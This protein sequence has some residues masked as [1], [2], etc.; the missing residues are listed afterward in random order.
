MG[1]VE[2]ELHNAK[3]YATKEAAT[4]GS[5]LRAPINTAVAQEKAAIDRELGVL[6]SAVER[7]HQVV[8]QLENAVSSVTTPLPPSD[9]SVP[10]HEQ[11]GSS[12]VY[13]SIHE[14]ATAL[15]FLEDRIGSVIR[16]LEV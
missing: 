9:G 6:H 13:F 3:A 14:A 2:E 1:P 16:N 8:T 5:Q 7:A 12:R 10:Q 4:I 15:H 11:V